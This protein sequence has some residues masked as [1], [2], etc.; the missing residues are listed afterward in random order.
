MMTTEN[1]VTETQERIK[2]HYPEGDLFGDA[3]IAYLE[4]NASTDESFIPRMLRGW[5]VVEQLKHEAEK[6]LEQ[7]DEHDFP[8]I[9]VRMQFTPIGEDVRI[10]LSP[11]YTRGQELDPIYMLGSI[12]Q[13]RMSKHLSPDKAA[14]Q[15]IDVFE[16]SDKSR[17]KVGVEL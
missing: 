10:K 15:I 9:G 8:N 2:K 17:Q 11:Y 3:D 1:W 14:S 5:P 12:T 13:H 6:Q 16:Q 4:F 7:H